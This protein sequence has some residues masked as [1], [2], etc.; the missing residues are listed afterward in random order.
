MLDLWEDYSKKLRK[1]DARE[2]AVSYA[3]PRPL[4][5]PVL[6][7]TYTSSET[8]NPETAVLRVWLKKNY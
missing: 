6:D 7:F 8:G 3:P 1:R 5:L 4:L 2:R